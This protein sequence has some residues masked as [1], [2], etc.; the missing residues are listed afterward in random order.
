MHA[1][2]SGE[3]GGARDSVDALRRS[4]HARL[5]HCERASAAFRYCDALLRVA[6]AWSQASHGLFGR[7]PRRFVVA[8]LLASQ[9]KW[10]Q[11]GDHLTDANWRLILAYAVARRDA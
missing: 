5:P 8:V 1:S 4:L 6:A 7:T 9:R 2:D 3:G 10:A 11:R